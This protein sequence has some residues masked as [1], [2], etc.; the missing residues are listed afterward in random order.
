MTRRETEMLVRTRYKQA[1]W[2][3]NG[4]CQMISAKR[5]SMTGRRLLASTAVLLV[6]VLGP[7]AFG[8]TYSGGVLPWEPSKTQPPTPVRPG[9]WAGM[10]ITA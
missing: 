6:T 4:D 10:R 2:R 5:Q 7:R 3:S 1:F 8:R 9:P